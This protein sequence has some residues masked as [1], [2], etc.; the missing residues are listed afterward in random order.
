[1][2]KKDN[3]VANIVGEGGEDFGGGSVGGGSVEDRRAEREHRAAQAELKKIRSEIDILSKKV[4]KLDGNNV[5]IDGDVLLAISTIATFFAN[6]KSFFGPSLVGVGATVLVRML[7]NDVSG[8]TPLNVFME[9][10]NIT[11]SLIDAVKRSDEATRRTIFIQE[12]ERELRKREVSIP[13]KE[14]WDY[15]PSPGGGVWA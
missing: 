7:W 6:P 2:I 8:Q 5:E 14:I 3:G 4:K 13:A 9:K 1:M 15:V 11:P 10:Y 12:V